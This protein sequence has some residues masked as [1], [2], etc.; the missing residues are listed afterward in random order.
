MNLVD[1]NTSTNATS[2]T[3]N[4]TQQQE[5][6]LTEVQFEN[7]SEQYHKYGIW[8]KYAQVGFDF[9]HYNTLLDQA[10]DQDMKHMIQYY[11]LFFKYLQD[12]PQ[13]SQGEFLLSPEF[14][15]NIAPRYHINFD[16]LP[17]A[18]ALASY[19]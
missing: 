3:S 13:I 11:P 7:L 4:N 15:R 9:T 18:S 12:H 1:S 17:A 10:S 16:T 14:V 8:D 2:A 19:Y 5:P 6:E